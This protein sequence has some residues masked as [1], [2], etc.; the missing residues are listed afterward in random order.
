MLLRANGQVALVYMGRNLKRVLEIAD[1]ATKKHVEKLKTDWRRI[2]K[3]PDR[4]K[5][6]YLEEWCDTGG[7]KKP[8]ARR[9]H[10]VFHDRPRGLR[11][12]E[13]RNTGV[14]VDCEL[15]FEKTRKGGWR[16]RILET[17]NEGPV[18]NWQAIPAGASSGDIIKLKVCG[19]SRR[20]GIAQLAVP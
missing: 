17:R 7:W 14:V 20:T 13:S 10:F 19:I 18:T 12:V 6:V 3:R 4:P 8:R 2:V 9:F 1:R 16:A 5:A 11:D 15:L